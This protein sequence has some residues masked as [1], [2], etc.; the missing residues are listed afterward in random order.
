MNKLYIYGIVAVLLLVAA[1]SISYTFHMKD[2][3][4]G[5]N[6][7]VKSA[8]DNEGFLGQLQ[9]Q[10]ECELEGVNSFSSFVEFGY[11]EEGQGVYNSANTKF[12]GKLRCGDHGTMTYELKNFKLADTIIGE[13]GDTDMYGNGQLTYE[14][15]IKVKKTIPVSFNVNTY[16]DTED[17]DNFFNM[18]SIDGLEDSFYLNLEKD[19]VQTF[20]HNR[21]C[22][23]GC[24]VEYDKT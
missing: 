6:L 24:E 16:Q 23:E 10:Y 5:S 1:S 7:D 9:T 12:K 17:K 14:L 19:D 21:Q 15:T 18:I 2:T 11:D 3:V 4:K 13:Y 20:T 22:L 8:D